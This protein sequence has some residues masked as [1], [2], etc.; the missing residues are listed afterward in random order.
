MIVRRTCIA[1]VLAHGAV[2]S[3]EQRVAVAET[4]E[5]APAAAA[6]LPASTAATSS[7]ARAAPDAIDAAAFAPSHRGLAAG[8]ELGEPI[9]ATVA[10]VTGRL[11]VAGALGSGTLEGPG[12]QA[13]ADAQV[14]V[15]RL[16]RAVPVRVGMGMRLYHHG[17]APASVDELPD[18]HLG[19]RASAA[20]ALERG[21][22]QLYVEAAPGIDVARSRS[23]ALSSGAFSVCPHAQQSPWFLQLA[24]GARW[25]LTD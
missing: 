22:L 4:H 23:C 12:L 13:H 25:F 3:A 10:Y 21:P 6:P 2:A 8:I 20:I 16:A 24:I 14:E 17:Y 1:I 11:L 19:L 18:T 9:S 15:T 7:E 5:A